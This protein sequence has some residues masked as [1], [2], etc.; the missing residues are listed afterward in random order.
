[1]VVSAVLAARP[2]YSDNGLPPARATKIQQPSA[3]SLNLL[4]CSAQWTTRCNCIMSMLIRHDR[5]RVACTDYPTGTYL[6]LLHSTTQNPAD[7]LY[8]P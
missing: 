1:M 2:A 4:L 8:E 3:T 6:D 7:G 5:I